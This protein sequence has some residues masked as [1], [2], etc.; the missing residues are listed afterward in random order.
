MKSYSFCEFSQEAMLLM[1]IDKY[2][3]IGWY[4]ESG[5]YIVKK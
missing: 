2:L 4:D 5:F 3:S 1:N